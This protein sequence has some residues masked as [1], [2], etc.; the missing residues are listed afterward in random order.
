MEGFERKIKNALKFDI[1]LV[2]AHAHASEHPLRVVNIP[3]VNF[4][5]TSDT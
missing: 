3:G 1:P 2:P 4:F 5:Q